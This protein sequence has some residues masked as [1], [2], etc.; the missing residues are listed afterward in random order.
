[1]HK[2][3]YCLFPGTLFDETSVI[4]FPQ[5]TKLTIIKPSN[6]GNYTLTEITGKLQGQ[7]IYFPKGK[8]K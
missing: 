1:M 6:S 8:W 3:G 5:L 7:Y 2:I 4:C